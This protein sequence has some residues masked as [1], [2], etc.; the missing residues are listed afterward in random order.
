LSLLS[1]HSTPH[2]QSIYLRYPST[3]QRFQSIITQLVYFD[4]QVTL[5]ICEHI[6]A[7][8]SLHTLGLSWFP[9]WGKFR[10]MI[11]VAV[12]VTANRQ[13]LSIELPFLPHP[14]LCDAVAFA[15][16]GNAVDNVARETPAKPSDTYKEVI[17]TF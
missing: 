4:E 3:G 16:G 9:A 8:P 17:R 1:K 13:Q 2:L 6:Q 10:D 15:L 14:T 12:R 11:S 7:L 5:W